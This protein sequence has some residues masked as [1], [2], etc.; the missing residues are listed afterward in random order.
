MGVA[1]IQELGQ[2]YYVL[3]IQARFPRHPVFLPFPGWRAS[4]RERCRRLAHHVA[5]ILREFDAGQ[6]RHFMQRGQGLDHAGEEMGGGG[7]RK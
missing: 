5:Q 2:H 3:L 6:P 4:T 7:V 1:G